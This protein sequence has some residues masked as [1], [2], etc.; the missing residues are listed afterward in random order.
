MRRNVGH[1]CGGPELREDI[2]MR[3]PWAKM[4]GESI[5][6]QAKFTWQRDQKHIM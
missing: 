3:Q 2:G 6:K 1:K 5:A 4:F